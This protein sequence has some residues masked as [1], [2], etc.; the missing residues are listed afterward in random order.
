MDLLKSSLQGLY[1]IKKRSKRKP[2]GQEILDIGS[3]KPWL[4]ITVVIDDIG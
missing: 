4:R 3:I 1:S 2:K